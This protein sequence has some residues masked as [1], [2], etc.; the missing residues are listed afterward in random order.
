MR[1]SHGETLGSAYHEDMNNATH[2]SNG[3]GRGDLVEIRQTE[4]EWVRATVLSAN[5][6]RVL[7]RYDGAFR[8]T[9][10]IRNLA[11]LRRAR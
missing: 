3:Y 7:V 9:E 4:T 1:I 2:I 6:S 5:E 10:A 11:H 8:T